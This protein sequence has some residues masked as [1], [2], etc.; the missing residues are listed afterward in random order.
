ML[1]SVLCFNWLGYQFVFDSL[2][3]KYNDLLEAKLD[4]DDYDESELISIKTAF[5]IPYFV[6]SN[7]FERWNGEVEVDGVKYK[8]VKRRFFNDSIEMLCIPNYAGTAI[9]SAK[10]SY[11]RFVNDFST[12]DANKKHTGLPAFKNL[13]TEF[14]QEAEE[15]DL[16]LETSAVKY[17]SFYQFYIP[18]VHIDNKGQPPDYSRPSF[19]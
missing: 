1:L 9:Q 13:L 3:K 17:F 2:E 8:Y 4:A 5:P 6:N 12:N 14:C 19:C 11:F 10:H 18:Q 15:W 7:R 16:G